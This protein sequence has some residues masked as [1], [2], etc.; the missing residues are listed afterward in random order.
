MKRSVLLPLTGIA[1]LG[2]GW[3]GFELYAASRILPGVQAAGVMVGGLTVPDASAKLR[4]ART[5]APVV[6]VSA[7]A[8]STNV[9]AT[10]L[11]W[12]ADYT[13]TAQ[14]AY[15]V[16]RDGNLLENMGKRFAGGKAVPLTAKVDP[17]TFQRR[18]ETLAKPFEVTPKSAAIVLIDRKS[19]V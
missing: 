2:L 9:N 19:V 11:G 1:A 18:L 13:A 17:K 10:E 12:R 4:S 7:G 5:K 14:A 16:G 3:G 15:S 6:R 8:Q